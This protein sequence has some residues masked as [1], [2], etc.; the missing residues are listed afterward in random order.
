[1]DLEKSE[2]YKVENYLVPFVPSCF[3]LDMHLDV[4]LTEKLPII[5][6]SSVLQ[7]KFSYFLILY[8][9]L[10]FRTYYFYEFG[11]DE[12]HAALVAA[13]NSGKVCCFIS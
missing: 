10:Y 8:H 13:V 11:R 3:R 6:L 7:I 2:L 5:K 4:M 9:D 12:Q 1:M